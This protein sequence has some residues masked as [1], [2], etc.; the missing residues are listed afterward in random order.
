MSKTNKKAGHYS[1][2]R[3]DRRIGGVGAAIYV[4]HEVQISIF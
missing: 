2:T 1:L 3:Q 4:F